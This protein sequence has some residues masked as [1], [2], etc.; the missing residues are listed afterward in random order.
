M[1][2][3]LRMN[4]VDS[5]NCLFLIPARLGSKRIPGKNFKELAG[6]TPLSR[7]IACAWNLQTRHPVVVS[8]DNTKYRPASSVVV[9]YREDR[10]ADDTALMIDVVKDAL[11]RWPGGDP[12]VLLQPT[13][14]LRRA[15]TVRKAITLLTED[16]DSVVTIGLD[17]FMRDGTAYVFWRRTVERF[18]TIYGKKVMLM[19]VPA[20]ET[21]PLDTPE[22][23]IEAERRLC[24][25]R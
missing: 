14:P 19:P 23:W 17:R 7:A 15:E 12:V 11:Q 18:G 16:I 13:Q 10:L 6:H 22:E 2:S 25:L 20:E 5:A 8:T 24:A 9:V 4:D 21:C 1:P 3:R